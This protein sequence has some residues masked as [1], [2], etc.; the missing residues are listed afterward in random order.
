[1]KLA[2]IITQKEDSKKL[3]EALVD[4]N[5]QLTKLD[6]AGGFLKKKNYTFLVGIGIEISIMFVLL[7]KRP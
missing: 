4:K 7:I 1:M 5:Y 6:S 2:I 3:E